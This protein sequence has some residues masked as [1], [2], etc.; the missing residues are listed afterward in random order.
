MKSSAKNAVLITRLLDAPIEHVWKAWTDPREIKR[1]WGPKNFTAPHISVHFHAGGKFLFCMHGAGP[2]GVVRNYWYTGKYVEIV[3]MNKLVMSMSFS[4]EHG[5][6]VPASHYAMP[7]DWPEEVK[8]TV[9][10]EEAP[11]G[12][13]RMTLRQSGIPNEML[14]ASSQGWN[15]SLDK[16]SESLDSLAGRIIAATAQRKHKLAA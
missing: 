12:K 4:D 1:W 15:Q 10:F 9:M 5:K 6:P 3:P 2:D 14:E 16:L 8:L 7:G 13:T 11:A